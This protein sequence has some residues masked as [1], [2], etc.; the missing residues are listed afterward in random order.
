MAAALS[1]GSASTQARQCKSCGITAT[2]TAVAGSLLSS[3]GCTSCTHT[4]RR[5]SG[6][7]PSERC[8]ALE[9]GGLELHPLRR[10]LVSLRADVRLTATASRTLTQGRLDDPST[11]RPTGYNSAQVGRARERGMK[12][13]HIVET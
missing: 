13:V 2:P 12:I 8:R 3:R 7:A 5:S 1:S 11:E 10:T 4:C 6:S 9:S